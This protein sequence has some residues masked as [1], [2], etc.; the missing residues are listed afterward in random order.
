VSVLA[1]TQARG[2]AQETSPL[3][4]SF[5]LLVQNWFK[6]RTRPLAAHAYTFPERTSKNFPPAVVELTRAP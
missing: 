5:F 2:A 4:P 1:D 6:K 3:K